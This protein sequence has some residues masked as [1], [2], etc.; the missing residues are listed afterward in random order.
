MNTFMQ[1]GWEAYLETSRISTMERKNRYL[2]S[3]KSYIVDVRLGSKYFSAADSCVMMK[4][5]LTKETKKDQT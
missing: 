4:T 3:Q 2:F 1:S 5:T